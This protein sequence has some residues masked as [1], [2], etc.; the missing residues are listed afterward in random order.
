MLSRPGYRSQSDPEPF[1]RKFVNHRNAGREGGPHPGPKQ[2]GERG[3]VRLALVP[4]YEKETHDREAQLNILHR[5]FN[6]PSLG[7]ATPF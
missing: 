6:L 1:T 2:R 4:D 5:L 7:S 3:K